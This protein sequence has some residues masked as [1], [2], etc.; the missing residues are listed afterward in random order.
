[1]R[2][3]KEIIQSARLTQAFPG[4]TGKQQI[5]T[6]YLNQVFYGHD[7]YGIAAAAQIYFGISKLSE[8]TPAQAALLAALPKSPSSLDPYRYAVTQ[9][10]GPAGRAA[11]RPADGPPR[12]D[13]RQPRRLALDA[14]DAAG[15]RGGARPS[16]S[17][18]A[19]TSR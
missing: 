5:I 4:Q 8:L 14:P 9:Q 11:G 7:A 15:A 17:S 10:E 12:L 13:P 3:A 1:M 6:A 19:A 18:C 2:K 16:P